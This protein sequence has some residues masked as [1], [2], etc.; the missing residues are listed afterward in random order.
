MYTSLLFCAYLKKLS[1]SYFS[2][3]HNPF[4]PNV[5]VAH[6]VVLN[7]VTTVTPVDS[8]PSKVSLSRLLKVDAARTRSGTNNNMNP[9]DKDQ[10]KVEMAVLKSTHTEWKRYR[11]LDMYLYNR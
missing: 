10:E 6:H 4:V 9:A 1:T 2:V 5:G 8:R 11:F 7:S 3:G